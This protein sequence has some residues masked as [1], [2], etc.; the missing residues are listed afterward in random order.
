[1]CFTRLLPQA[2]SST[3]TPL[4]WATRTCMSIVIMGAAL[5]VHHAPIDIEMPGQL[6]L[7]THFCRGLACAYVR[8]CSCSGPRHEAFLLVGAYLKMRITI[9]HHLAQRC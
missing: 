8:V 7:Q 6:H 2:H 9:F 3:V 4:V 1:M 5:A